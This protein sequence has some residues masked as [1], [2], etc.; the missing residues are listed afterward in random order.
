VVQS[1]AFKVGAESRQ[2]DRDHEQQRVGEAE[3]DAGQAFEDGD[4]FGVVVHDI[5]VGVVAW[6][7]DELVG[8][9]EYVGTDADVW[10]SH[11][12]VAIP[13]L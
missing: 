11:N 13:L 1:V 9:D 12:C 8:F 7:C 4:D 10:F 6:S 3:S 5:A 2:F